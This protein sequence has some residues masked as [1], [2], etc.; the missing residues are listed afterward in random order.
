[1]KL[2]RISASLMA[3]GMITALAAC[4]GGGGGGGTLPNPGGGGGGPTPKPS[5][6]PTS[7]P[8]SSPTTSPT[9]SPTSSPTSQPTG[10]VITSNGHIAR[11]YDGTTSP[12]VFGSDNW[13]KNGA[14]SSDP[15][16]GDIAGGFATSTGKSSYDGVNCNLGSEAMLTSTSYHVHS[17][18][19]IFVN[20][21]QYAIPDAI[22]MQNP[23][24]DE[25]VSNFSAACYI[26]T[27]APSGIIHV[28]DPSQ[29]NAFTKEYAQ[30]N[31]QSLLDLWGQGSVANIATATAAFSGP[32]S[33]YVGTPCGGTTVG[34]AN[35]QK[36]PSTNEELVTS[37]TLQTGAPSTIE[38]GHHVAIWIVVG[39]M[40]AAG[41]PGIDFGISN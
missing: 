29:T 25:P 7:S 11:I 6:S 12:L 34:C 18:L 17:F 37:Y 9:Q 4:G 13:Q 41:L 24:S 2:L 38:L 26:H 27:H 20:G 14:S 33:I 15:G 16:D 36:N 30:Y 40:P 31:L 1:M 21:V 32:V 23:T 5:T 28:E 35:P 19:G 8:T 3:F 10:S 22:G 39:S